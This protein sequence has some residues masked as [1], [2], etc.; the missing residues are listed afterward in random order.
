MRNVDEGPASKAGDYGQTAGQI[1]YGHDRSRDVRGIKTERSG[2]R[3]GNVDG[4]GTW[5]ITTEQKRKR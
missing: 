5:G 1:G 2:E 3:R 4:D